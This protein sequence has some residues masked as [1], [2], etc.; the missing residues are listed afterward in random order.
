MPEFEQ[1]QD[2]MQQAVK[3]ERKFLRGLTRKEYKTAWGFCLAYTF[4][5]LY[6]LLAAIG[7][8][9]LIVGYVKMIQKE[10]LTFFNI[11]GPTIF[12]F[13]CVTMGTLGVKVSRKLLLS[14][15]RRKRKF[16]QKAYL[17]L[18]FFTLFEILLLIYLCLVF[19]EGN[20][21]F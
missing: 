20:F 8:T 18:S 19:L 15:K 4:A 11:I 16:K 3:E 12:L 14:L 2:I 9:A 7:I 17:W 13:A 10:A 6:H 1:K 5:S 21:I